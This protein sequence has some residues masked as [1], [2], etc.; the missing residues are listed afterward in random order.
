MLTGP[1]EHFNSGPVPC[2]VLACPIACLE[3]VQLGQVL[4]QINVALRPYTS[5][6][7]GRQN[8]TSV[9]PV[10]CWCINN[11]QNH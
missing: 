4:R 6:C 1:R 9:G 11:G 5:S 2:P 10:G 7:T 3:P 8:I